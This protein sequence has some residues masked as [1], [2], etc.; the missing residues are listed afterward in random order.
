[1]KNKLE[2][3]VRENK[4][5][6]EVK[7][8]SEQLWERIS[9]ELDKKETPKKS[10]KLYQW[11]SIA[12]MLAISLGI[13]FSYNH[14]GGKN[15]SITVADVNPAIGKRAV[16]FTSQIE[17]KKDSLD[18]YAKEN[19]ELYNKFTTDLQK[20]DADYE[21]LKKELQ[22]TPNRP[23][24]VKAMMKNLEIRNQILSQQLQIINQVN[25]FNKENSI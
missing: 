15:T 1:M 13:Y 7:G 11:L 24:V 17:E 16:Q 25:Q 3:F 5:Q 6:F 4:K 23:F 14:S 9:A 8:P 18:V 20:L 10:I 21:K 19:P 22:T 12:A 2:E